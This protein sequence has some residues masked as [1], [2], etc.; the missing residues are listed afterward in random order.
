MSECH[1][2][3]CV[4]FQDSLG[5]QFVTTW[6]IPCYEQ[7]WLKTKPDDEIGEEEGR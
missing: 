2:K 1:W 3:H 7:L 6:Q 5:S 4:T